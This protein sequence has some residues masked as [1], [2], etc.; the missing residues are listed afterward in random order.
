MA[1]RLGGNEV[2][3]RLGDATPSAV[4]LGSQE[5]WSAGG[6]T[7]GFNF[8]PNNLVLVYDTSLEP[9]NNTVSVPLGNVNAPASFCTIDWG[10]GSSESH[11]FSFGFKTHTYANPGVYVV[12]I[13][14]TLPTFS[15]GFGLVTANNR[16]KLTRCLSFGNI[17]LMS[18]SNAF[19]NCANLIQC[20]AA[21]PGTVTNMGGMF[22][23]A[24]A[25]NQDIGGWN[26]ASATDMASMFSGATAFNQPIGGWNTASVT[27]M[28][29]MFFN[30]TAFNQPIGGWNTASVTTMA[31]MFSGATSFNQPIGGWNTASVTNIQ[32]MFSGATSFNQPI[33][34]WNTASVTTMANMFFNATAFNQDIGGWNISGLTTGGSLNFFLSGVTLGVANYDALLIAWDANKASYRSDLLPNFGS[35]KYTAGGAAAA[36]RAALVAYGWTITDGGTA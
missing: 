34:G 4:Y 33:G 28:A 10:D 29:N 35:S 24:T 14:G 1:T 17:G 7:G 3:F 25:F 32:N 2:G 13:S 12:Q 36:A 31:N 23:N 20:P 18:L 6:E 21:V 16:S 5:V 15:Y 30:A 8:N 26:T 9:E 22:F 27:T 11:D 19:R